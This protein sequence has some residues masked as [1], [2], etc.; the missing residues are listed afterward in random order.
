MACPKCGSDQ[1][2]RSDSLQYPFPIEG[3]EV[4]VAYG[5]V[6]C[7]QCNTALGETTGSEIELAIAQLI[8]RVG[9]GTG[10]AFAHIR[11]SLRYR[12][13]DIA[14]LFQVRPETVSHWENT[15]GAIDRPAWIALGALLE[16]RIA[17]RT[18]IEDRL[19]SALKPEIPKSLVKLD[20][21]IWRTDRPEPRPVPRVQMVPNLRRR[22]VRKRRGRA[23]RPASSSPPRTGR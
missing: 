8:F 21:P 4:E 10:P 20:A 11:K 14:A 19:F 17:C 13:K 5:K 12:A 15:P 6:T 1:E 2:V 9:I 16:D 23:R 3:M 18:T 22:T 7:A